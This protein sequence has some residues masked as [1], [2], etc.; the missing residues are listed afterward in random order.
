MWCFETVFG[1]AAR[2]RHTVVSPD[3]PPRGAHDPRVSPASVPDAQINALLAHHQID[4]VLDVGANSGRYALDL[5][6]AGYA[7][8]ILSFEPV[9]D[10]WERC[11]ANAS[12]DPLWSVA[13]QVA[14]GARE[15]Q[16]EIHVSRNSVSSSIL[17]MND[18]HRAAAPDSSYVRTERVDL[19]RLDRLAREPIERARRPFLKIDT[20]GYE[21]DLSRGRPMC[22]I[23]CGDPARDFTDSAVQRQPYARRDL[24]D[25][26]GMAVCSAGTPP[27][28]HRSSVR[29]DASGRR[30]V[31]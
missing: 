14:L 30:P 18:V 28:L 7:G 19:R 13:P 10:A 12:R 17:P 24:E 3:P 15:G 29:T 20:Q 27:W 26:G 5:R 31:L 23:G 8:Q 4:L 22:S 9:R 16:V 25:D 11:V 6:R 2:E 1:A 21:R